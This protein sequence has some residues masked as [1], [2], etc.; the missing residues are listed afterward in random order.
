MEGKKDYSRNIFYV[1]VPHFDYICFCTWLHV[2]EKRRR[3]ER[4][5]IFYY[6]S[7]YSIEK[8]SVWSWIQGRQWHEVTRS[9]RICPLNNFVCASTFTS[10]PKFLL[11]TL[12]AT[13]SFLANPYNRL[14]L[15][16]ESD[17]CWWWRGLVLSRQIDSAGTSPCVGIHMNARL[18]F[19][20]QLDFL[21]EKIAMCYRK[22]YIF[23]YG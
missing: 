7:Y 14:F 13:K 10:L 12:T 6:E 16:T 19:G 22:I 17:G 23:A 8:C 21:C 11:Q 20:V 5:I 9:P 4:L 15:V 2:K 3:T 1:L 18:L